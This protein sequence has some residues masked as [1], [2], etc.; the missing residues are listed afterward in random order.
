VVLL[1]VLA[2]PTLLLGIYFTPL[3]NWANESAGILNFGF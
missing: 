1:L 2:I 3:V